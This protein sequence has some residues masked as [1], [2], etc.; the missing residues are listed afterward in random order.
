MALWADVEIFQFAGEVYQ[1]SLLP[2]RFD[3]VR[4][5][6]EAVS[7]WM[8]TILVYQYEGMMNRPGSGTYKPVLARI[9]PSTDTDL[10]TNRFKDAAGERPYQIHR[11]IPM[12]SARAVI[13]H[14]V[15]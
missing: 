3:R 14:R 7:P 1:S 6:L 11:S 5:Q 15:E 12:P 9:D 8:D 2:A 13:G 10:P 4:R